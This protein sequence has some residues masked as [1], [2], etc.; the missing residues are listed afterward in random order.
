[1]NNQ[2]KTS[3]LGEF[4]AGKGF[5]V[6]LFICVAAV[7]ISGY[8]LFFGAG[9]GDSYTP[10]E[11][12]LEWVEPDAT[13]HPARVVTPAPLAS[14]QP[15]AA[16]EPSPTLP[17]GLPTLPDASP[18]ADSQEMSAADEG[19]VQAASSTEIPAPPKTQEKPA[20][21]PADTSDTKAVASSDGLYYWPVSGS[22]AVA[23]SLDELLFNSTMGDW[24]THAGID[25]ETS[26]GAAV[27]AAAAGKVISITDDP[28]WGKTITLDH[29]G[30][31]TS[32]YAN[33]MPDIS[34]ALGANVKA[35]DI[36]GGVGESAVT[37][38]DQNPHLHFEMLQNDAP[39]DP[40]TL[41]P[42][43]AG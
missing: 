35:G 15:T 40:V 32:V 19:R 21:Q 23:H 34:V 33:L 12:S 3:R 26:A 31:L 20:T 41:L 10:D 25:I 5:Y 13:T 6:V 1:M 42:Q 16:P 29:G 27:C 11:L 17:G 8:V 43:K 4:F 36:L 18:P 37:E 2:N 39:V 28:V 24:R 7:G 22:V 30:G 14:A 9:D 38:I